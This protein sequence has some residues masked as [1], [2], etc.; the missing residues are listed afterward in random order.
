MWP[1]RFRRLGGMCWGDDPAY[2]H[3]LVGRLVATGLACRQG[4]VGRLVADGAPVRAQ[5]VAGAV[6]EAWR[7][8]L[9]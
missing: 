4:L 2:R 5:D 7:N 8:V 9:G 6:P 1:G 3:G